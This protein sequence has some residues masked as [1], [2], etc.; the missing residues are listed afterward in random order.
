M[1]CSSQPSCC[2][3]GT[4]FILYQWLLLDDP[5]TGPAACTPE[6]CGIMALDRLPPGFYW[7]YWHIWNT[8]HF[9][10]FS[11]IKGISDWWLMT[12][13]KCGMLPL[14]DSSA[15]ETLPA[16]SLWIGFT[17]WILQGFTEYLRYSKIGKLLICRGNH[18]HQTSRM[19]LCRPRAA[20]IF[21]W[22]LVQGYRPWC[23]YGINSCSALSS[24]SLLSLDTFTWVQH[25]W[26][27]E[28]S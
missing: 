13:E 26:S 16:C 17:G 5:P 2:Q 15:T 20:F 28:W 10:G 22:H 4:P 3:D 24:W 27:P 23:N 18:Q 14:G 11:R 6:K 1:V 9:E 25:G 7:M 8:Q 21:I 12:P 19:D